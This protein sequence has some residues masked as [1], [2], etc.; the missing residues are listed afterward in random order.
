ME[1]TLENFARKTYYDYFQTYDVTLIC[2]LFVK[3]LYSSYMLY[4]K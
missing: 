2:S 3:I 1:T 4:N